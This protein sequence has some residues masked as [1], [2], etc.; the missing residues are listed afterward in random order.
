L[1]AQG[2]RHI[3][4]RYDFNSW[5]LPNELIEAI[6]DLFEDVFAPLNLKTGGKAVEVLADS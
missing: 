3:F 6:K 1:L 2:K 4:F 5:I